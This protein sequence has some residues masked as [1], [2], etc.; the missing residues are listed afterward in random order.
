MNSNAGPSNAELDIDS[1]LREYRPNSTGS[2]LSASSTLSVSGCAD[3]RTETAANG[4]DPTEKKIYSTQQNDSKT[5]LTFTSNV[6]FFFFFQHVFV[7]D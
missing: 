2:S 4:K 3:D 6:F 1:R 5:A 7:E